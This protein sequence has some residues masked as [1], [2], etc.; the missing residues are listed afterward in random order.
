MWYN[1]SRAKFYVYD[2]LVFYVV[3]FAENVLQYEKKLVSD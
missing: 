3:Y 1:E 2:Y